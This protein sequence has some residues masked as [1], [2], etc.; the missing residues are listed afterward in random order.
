[1][2]V[3]AVMSF[4]TC[5]GNVGDECNISLPP[6]ATKNGN[7]FYKDQHG[8]E[9]TDYISWSVDNLPVG[10]GRTPVQIYSDF[11]KSFASTFNSMI[12]NTIDE[13]QV[14]L[15]PAGELR[16]PS[17]PLDK[18]NFPRVGAFQ[19]YDKNMLNDLAAAASAA[20][21]ADWGHG[22]PNNAGDYNS[23]PDDTGFFNPNCACDNYKSTY[24][25]FFLNWY[26]SRLISHGDRILSAAKSIFSNRLSIAAKVSGVHWQYFH[27]SHAAELTA[28]YKNDL[29]NG[30][31]P[32]AKMF[33]KNN[34]TM[35]FTCLEM[36]DSEQQQ[37]GCAPVELIRQ[38]KLSALNNKI[39]YSGENA[40]PRYDNTA[41]NQILY[42]GTNVIS[43][44]A[45][46][47]LRLGST[48]FDASN[49]GNFKS[50]VQNMH[51]LK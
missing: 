9:E 24:G 40:L 43:L 1:L 28:G 11:M 16:Y 4:H 7:V 47:Y 42:Q 3:Q 37:C 44:H 29:G 48:L 38:T 34:V 36:K 23:W 35:I 50:F 22:G 10:G 14:G 15:G 27:A 26:S 8:H 33:A 51:N 45:F 12:G 31:D 49:W 17:Y 32:I 41:Y 6:W 20:G 13:V 19:C 21:H 2:K 39:R 18:W 46:T 5:G 30:Y 25:Q